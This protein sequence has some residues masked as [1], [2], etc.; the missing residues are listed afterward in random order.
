[1]FAPPELSDTDRFS[2]KTVLI[3]FLVNILMIAIVATVLG[4]TSQALARPTQIKTEQKPCA[5][6]ERSWLTGA[7]NP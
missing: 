3:G 2:L 4:A 5:F 6:V 1:M 7:V